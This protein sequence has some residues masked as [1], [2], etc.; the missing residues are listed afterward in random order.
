MKYKD[1]LIQ[2]ASM[3]IPY[4]YDDTIS[5]LELNRKLYKIV[6]E[7]IVAMQ[8]LSN[9]YDTLENHVDEYFNNLNLSSEVQAIINKMVEDGTLAEIINSELFDNLNQ[10]ISTINESI[11]GI[12]QNIT[13]LQDSTKNN[14]DN[15]TNLEARSILHVAECNENANYF[16]N[17]D[18]LEIKLNDIIYIHFS[19]AI[20]DTSDATLTINNV[21]RNVINKEGSLFKGQDLENK[22]LILKVSNV[23]LIQ[24]VDV[25]DLQEQINN[26]Q[27]QINNIKENFNKNVLD[28]IYPV[29]SIIYN[30]DENFDPNTIFGGTW[31]KIKGK[32]IFGYDDADDDFST[33]KKT[34]GS[35]THTQTINEMPRHNHEIT[36][37]TTSPGSNV[38]G[39]VLLANGQTEQKFP[40][41]DAGNGQAM[42]IMNPYYVANIWRRVA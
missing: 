42:D 13:E 18:S 19:P 5:F 32:L 8:G 1:I 36:Y 9:N 7:L 26:N 6:H 34:G 14:S 31:E 20:V 39:T 17:D 23:G 16:I 4:V 10:E 37:N 21:A 27:E 33:L 11:S 35:K 15:I 24:I 30:D 38:G 2:L 40:V 25:A 29:G 3:T 41:T 22:D 28:F 12:N